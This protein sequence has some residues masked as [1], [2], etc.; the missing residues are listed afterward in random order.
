MAIVEIKLQ[1]YVSKKTNLQALELYV[2]LPSHPIP[3]RRSTQIKTLKN[4]WDPVKMRIRGSDPQAKKD[5]LILASQI[6]RANEIIKEYLLRE[7]PLSMDVFVQN[8]ESP[9]LKGDFL[10]FYAESLQLDYSRGIIGKGTLEAQER[11]LKK[12]KEFSSILSIAQMDRS[13]L[14]RFDAWHARFLEK[15]GFD[16]YPEREKALKHIRKYLKRA[17]EEY[18]KK[19]EH[20]WPFKGFVWPRYQVKPVF[21][22]EEEIKLIIS[23]YRNPEVIYKAMLKEAERREMNP[24]NIGQYANDSGVQ[25]IQRIMR[26]FLFQC[27]SGVRYSDLSRLTWRHIEGKHLCFVP[28]KTRHSSGV[29]VKMLLTKPL[30]ELL[31]PKKKQGRIF[32]VIS[33]QKYNQYLKE[34]ARI[35]ELD[36]PI[37]SHVGRHTF[38]TMSLN[39]GIPVERL[40]YLMGVKSIKTLMIYVHITQKGIDESMKKAYGRF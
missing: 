39:R 31:P 10:A 18:D 29:S 7:I 35:V 23:Y 19:G 21:L 22:T 25:R 2:K 8:F 17:L 24:W 28:W 16:G 34:V 37:T 30:K 38:A 3:F 14:E 15:K 1:P 27:F 4:K 20:P 36:K 40:K 6:H 33:N 32:Q 9:A 5:N 11:T 13:T 26:H 12:L